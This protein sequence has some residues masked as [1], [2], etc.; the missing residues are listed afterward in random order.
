MNH[1]ECSN[2]ERAKMDHGMKE[3]SFHRCPLCGKQFSEGEVKCSGCLLSKNCNL[4]CCPHCG[5]SFKER[6]A[7][8]DFLKKFLGR[9]VNP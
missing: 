9:K 4:L 2:G 6:S 8:V 1:E 5:Y 7:I 3:Q